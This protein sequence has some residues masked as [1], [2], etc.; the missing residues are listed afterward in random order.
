M[1][2][3]AIIKKTKPKFQRAGARL[4]DGSRMSLEG[5]NIE[6]DPLRVGARLLDERLMF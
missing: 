3:K 5:D 2:F 4:L 1:F 6:I